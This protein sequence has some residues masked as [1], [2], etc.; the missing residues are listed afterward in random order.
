MFEII[1]PHTGTV[2][3]TFLPGEENL[4]GAFI[5]DTDFEVREAVTI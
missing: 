1:D 2:V 5:R 3:A 4:I